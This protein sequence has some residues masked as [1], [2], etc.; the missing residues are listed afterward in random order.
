MNWWAR[1]LEDVLLEETGGGPLV[2]SRLGVWN[3]DTV[4]R[5]AG[6]LTYL[7]EEE[8]VVDQMFGARS[9][10]AQAMLGKFGYREAVEASAYRLRKKAAIPRHV[11]PYVGYKD[12]LLNP[13][14]VKKQAA[15]FREFIE[16]LKTVLIDN[17]LEA[18][19]IKDDST[20]WKSVSTDLDD[21]L[22]LIEA[23]KTSAAL[24]SIADDVRKMFRDKLDAAD[25][26][27]AK[28]KLCRET[29]KDSGRKITF[30][31]IAAMDFLVE[32]LGPDALEDL[33]PYL[34]HDYWRLRDHSRKLAAELVAAGGAEQ[35]AG[36]F[37]Q[38]TGAASSRHS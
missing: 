33:V 10:A 8:Q 18:V 23:G 32:T 27:G 1:A 31:M 36:L 13:E 6:P 34:G 22:A 28:L 19:V 24:P 29:L 17:P 3:K 37:A 2:E 26:T 5:L 25:G 4:V 12:P 15:A 38:N 21:M 30:Q 35:L 16:P 7:A 20:N 14:V 9:Q 11:R